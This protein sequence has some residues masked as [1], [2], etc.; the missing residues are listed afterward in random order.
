MSRTIVRHCGGALLAIACL[1]CAEGALAT[2]S[3]QKATV[4][5]TSPEYLRIIRSIAG[6]REVVLANKPS[7]EAPRRARPVSRA[8]A[9]VAAVSGPAEGQAGY[10]HYF[11]L[12][13][14]DGSTEV[15]IGIETHDQQ[16]AWSFP[17]VGAVV[18]RFIDA[19]VV[20]AG[21][22]DFEIW[23]LYGL[24][25]FPD[26]A[27]M[28][29]LQKAL[30]GRIRTWTER[31]T[32]YCED[33]GPDSR[34]M[35]CLGF[36]M[37]VL[38]PGRTSPYPDVPRDFQRAVTGARYTTHDLLLYLTGMFDLP[39]RDA[40]MR[41]IARLSVPDNLRA[42]LSILVRTMRPVAAAPAAG[43]GQAANAAPKP[44]A[45]GARSNE[46]KKL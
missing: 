1:I 21:G 41:R 8:T 16:I 40:R 36:V 2:L 6:A 34:C 10:V 27:S 15:Q 3:A 18:S 12:R 30:P 42:D 32:P 46:R 33:D 17:E 19:A 13:L 45:A 31:N 14:P 39:S 35:S 9:P 37:R 11:L 25:P 22:K 20:E 43:P 23:H 38:F 24:R 5:G 7:G 26:D 4:N 28:A 29:P 44:P